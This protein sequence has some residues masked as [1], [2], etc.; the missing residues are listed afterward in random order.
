MKILIAEDDFV[1]RL[2][3]QGILKSYGPVHIAV[4]S[5]EA[6]EAVRLALKPVEPFDLICLDIMMPEMSGKEALKE[7]RRIE[8][9]AGAVASNRTKT[10][11][12]TT[13]ADQGHVREAMRGRCDCLLTK[14]IRKTQ[15][16]EWSCTRW[17]SS[18][19]AEVF[20]CAS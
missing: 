20:Q 7:I 19:E 10:V 16:L 1:S 17:R 18:P 8:R 2:L 5:K 15:G 9:A 6:V 14:P 12:T 13:L 3:L 4:N 11:M